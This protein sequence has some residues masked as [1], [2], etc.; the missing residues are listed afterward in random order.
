MRALVRANPSPR[1]WSWIYRRRDANRISSLL[2][3]ILATIPQCCTSSMPSSWQVHRVR[4]TE[5]G[6]TVASLGVAGHSPA[7]ILRLPWSADGTARLR[8]HND[9]LVMLHRDSRL[10]RYST[11][12]P[13]PLAF[14]VLGEQSFAVEQALEGR[15]GTDF[16]LDRPVRVQLLR[17]AV[18]AIGDLHKA[19]STPTLI[20]DD[21]LSHWIDRRFDLMMQLIAP[22]R[23]ADSYATS[24]SQLASYIRASLRGRQLAVGWI[25]GDFWLGNLLTTSDGSAVTGIV[26]WEWAA[27][28][29]LPAH[30]IL[31]LLLYT[32]CL[33][34]H[35]DLGDILCELLNGAPWPADDAALLQELQ[36]GVFDDAASRAL[37]LL[38]WLRH[39]TSNIE[40][41]MAYINHRRWFENNVASVLRLF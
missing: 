10:R 27:D 28:E 1:L 38:Y 8:R 9:V 12:V 6:M 39:I 3:A 2:P 20:T 30:D 22:Q 41:S 26:D 5:S 36:G 16:L 19:T 40:Q 25:H 24:L 37:C 35:R 11:L 23:S 15:P 21:L 14:G 32:R 18:R 13:R 29:E 4:R 33:V 7:A 31:H 17:A 34:E